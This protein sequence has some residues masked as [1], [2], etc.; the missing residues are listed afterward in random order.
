MCS[1]NARRLI[2][3]KFET[4]ILLVASYIYYGIEYSFHLYTVR[5]YCSRSVMEHRPSLTEPHYIEVVHP[6]YMSTDLYSSKL[7]LLPT[8]IPIQSLVNRQQ[9][10]II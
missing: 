4:C 9:L 1:V 8:H 3:P 5:R 10:F 6:L 2:Q 7:R